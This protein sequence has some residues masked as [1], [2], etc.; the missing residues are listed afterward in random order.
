MLSTSTIV[1]NSYVNFNCY[2]PGV[3]GNGYQG[4]EVLAILDYDSANKITPN[5]ATQWASV[6]PSIQQYGYVN[7]YTK[8]P[9]LKIRTSNGTV[10]TVAFPWI[11]DSSYVVQ[12]AAQLTIVI[13]SVNPAD[14]ANIEAALAGINITNYTITS[15]APGTSPTP[16]PSPTPSPSSGS[17]VTPG[18]DFNFT[19]TGLQASFTDTSVDSNT[20]SAWSWN[21]G[22]G[23]GSSTQQNPT[24]TYA[25]SG[26]YV[27]TLTITDTT[28]TSYQVNDSVTVTAPA[29]TP[30]PTPSPTPS[31]NPSPS[32]SP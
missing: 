3:L 11:V 7:D 28:N 32:P 13:A 6:Y 25:A 9:Y 18:A 14:Q 26:T 15:S 30:T 16:T 17:A 29:P 19:V 24:Y 27:V 2:A 8:Y 10:T 22:D 12:T 23:S 5:L 4:A 21:F 31:P 1:F 20:I